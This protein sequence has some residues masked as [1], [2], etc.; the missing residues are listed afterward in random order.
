MR[1]CL[2]A[3]TDRG[4]SAGARLS[5]GVGRCVGHAGAAPVDDGRRRSAKSGTLTTVIRLRGAAGLVVLVVLLVLVVSGLAL[6]HRS[7]HVTRAP[8]ARASTTAA[9]L[10]MLDDWDARRADAYAA[11]SADGLRDLYVPGSGAGT[12]DLRLL[13]RYQARG[14]RVIDLHM[15]V[16]GLAVTERRPDRWTLRVTD[17]LAGAVAVHG[18]QRTPL[19]RDTASTHVVTLL[20]GGDGRW[21]VARV[22]SSTTRGRP[23]GGP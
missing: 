2:R 19:P 20:R 6:T 4:L 11:A 15:Q 1:S 5:A 16:L 13:G 23:R 21:R 18:E 3:T 7:P 22:A 10:A 9:A 8:A 12:A 17:R 14:L